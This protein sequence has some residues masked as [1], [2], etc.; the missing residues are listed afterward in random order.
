MANYGQYSKAHHS[1]FFI[2]IL[3][4]VVGFRPTFGGQSAR[5]GVFLAPWVELGL[6]TL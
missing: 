4:I 6:A 2:I 1:S 5:F 3:S